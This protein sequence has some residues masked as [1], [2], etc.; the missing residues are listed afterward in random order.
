MYERKENIRSRHI[1]YCR[2]VDLAPEN[3][4]LL[5]YGILITLIYRTNYTTIV[6]NIY[7][8]LRYFSL[9]TYEVRNTK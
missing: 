8:N 4:A 1:T 2:S 5:V 3:S 6:S 9:F 7:E